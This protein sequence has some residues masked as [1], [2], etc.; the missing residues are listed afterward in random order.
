MSGSGASNLGYGG[1]KPFSNVD[2]NFANKG[3]TNNPASF[4]S[5]EIPK[6]GPNG[7]YGVVDNVKA[8][9]GN[10][11]SLSFFKGGGGGRRRKLLR[12]KIKNITRKYKSSSRRM[13][14]SLKRR[15]S[16]KRSL[17]MTGGNPKSFYGGSGA[18]VPYNNQAMAYGYALGGPMA[19]DSGKN[20][21]LA[22]PPLLHRYIGGKRRRK[23]RSRRTRR[24]TIS[25]RQRGGSYGMMSGVPKLQFGTCNG[26]NDFYNHYTKSCGTLPK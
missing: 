26:C 6:G 15:F 12:Q 7:L 13:R 22:N 9:G 11:N 17:T 23:S 5:N 4:G 18:P 10:I 1:T 8:I 24:R 21:A 14:R 20:I 2:G 16:K 25:R 19:I 3:S